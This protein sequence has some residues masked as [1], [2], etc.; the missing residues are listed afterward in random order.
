MRTLAITVVFLSATLTA[1]AVA[2]PFNA[3]Y[4]VVDLGQIPGITQYG[5]NA[6]VPGNPN[7]M[8][9][10]PYTSGQVFAVTLTRDL[11][12]N[13]TGASGATSVATVG[14]TDGGL[15]Y[16]PGNVLFGTWYGPNRLWQVKPGSNVSDRVDDLGPLGVGGSVGGCAFVPAGMPGAGKLKVVSYSS[17]QWCEVPLTPDGLGTQAPGNATVTLTLQG[18]PEGIVYTP[19]AAP[20][21]GGQVLV[22][23]WANGNVVA[24]QVDANGD[25][26]PATRQVVVGG[27]NYIGGGAVDPLTGDLVF[28]FG[29]GRMLA[30]RSGSVCGS[31]SHYGVA[32]PGAG[33]VPALGATGCSRIGQTITLQFSGPQNGIGLLAYGSY[34]L[35]FVWN[36]LTV[37]TPIQV[38]AVV[39]LDATGQATL[40]LAIPANPLLGYTHGYMQ[41]AVLDASTASGFASSDG[42]DLQFR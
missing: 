17:N 32:T 23:E 25:P 22:A 13:I 28:L 1:Q 11:L 14:G 9:V 6:F 12:G 38:T 27:A 4:Q 35:T 5:G 39:V 20:L 2:P 19:P 8:V 36:G 21:I 24:Y 15:A 7:L 26:L 31:V 41:Y 3:N 29:S 40:P 33:P 37:L 42:L 10:S 16:G 30:L 18:G 34:P